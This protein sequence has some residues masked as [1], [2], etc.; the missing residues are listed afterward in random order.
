MSAVVITIAPIFAIIFLGALLRR[1]GFIAPEII[2]PVNR[3]VFF[4]AIPA[5]VFSKISAA[6]FSE[7]YDPLLIALT[8]TPLLLIAPISL[9]LGRVLGLSGG[10]LGSFIQTSTH[11]NTGYIGL[12][13]AFYYLGDEGLTRASF[14]IA[15]LFLLQNSLSVLSLAGL[16]G[17]Q[18][19]GIG[20][21]IHRVAVN[22][23]ILSATA[24]IAWSLS[25]LT[26]PPI[27]GRGL[28]ILAGMALPSALLVLGAS[29]NFASLRAGTGLGLIIC[30][31]KLILMPALAWAGFTLAGLD[32]AV[33]LP[34][35]I[36]LTMPTGTVSFVL[37]EQMGGDAELTATTISLTTL[38]SALTVAG[39]LV[40]I[41][42]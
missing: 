40:L 21:L 28:D 31:L 17:A 8:L 30:G 15:F 4:V 22:P 10:R 1:T 12:A 37:A 7:L 24:G 9:A 2:G 18:R 38:V 3:L 19:P 27:L 42:I 23:I 13:V 5:M 11:G 14:L 32:T 41:R 16:G 26:L 35:L 33:Y 29:L 34:G 39:W 20:A 6:P 25:G 36:L